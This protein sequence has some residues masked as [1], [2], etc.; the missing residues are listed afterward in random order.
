MFFHSVFK[1]PHTDLPDTNL[2]ALQDGRAMTLDGRVVG[3]DN[4]QQG[5]ERYITNILVGIKQEPT[6]DVDGQDLLGCDNMRFSL[7]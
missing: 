1:V 7:Q 2:E 4:P 3:M 5:V 6:K